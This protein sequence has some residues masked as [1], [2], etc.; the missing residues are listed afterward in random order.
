MYRD[1]P[2]GTESVAD[3]VWDKRLFFSPDPG[4]PSI[5]HVRMTAS[6]W[7]RYTVQFRDWLRAQPAER[8]RYERVK[9]KLA[10]AH[11]GDPD[12]DDYTRAKSA[13]FDR[14][15]PLFERWSHGPG[16]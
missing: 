6:P 8:D 16:G 9:Q 7:G 1:I 3:H 14:A 2:C 11:A 5:L 12:Y 13:Y 15:Q 10:Q 4:Q